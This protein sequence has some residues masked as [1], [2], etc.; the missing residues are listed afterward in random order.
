[1][2]RFVLLGQLFYMV[3]KKN[4]LLKLKSGSCSMR[5]VDLFWE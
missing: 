5:T 2:P 3:E 1:M 4:R